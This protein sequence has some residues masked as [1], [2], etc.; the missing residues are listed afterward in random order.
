MFCIIIYYIIY[1]KEE[2]EVLYP[3]RDN[4]K[5]AKM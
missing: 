1:R 3:E 5:K 4:F 2:E